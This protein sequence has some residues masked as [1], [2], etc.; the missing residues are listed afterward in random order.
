MIKLTYNTDNSLF[1]DDLLR[2]TLEMSSSASLSDLLS[3]VDIFIK[4]IGYDTKGDL[5]YTETE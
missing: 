2:F 1:D 3:N 4:A 5:I